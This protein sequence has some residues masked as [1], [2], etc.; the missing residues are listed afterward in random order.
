MGE[1]W[2]ARDTRL[3][4]MV[5]IKRLKVQHSA[6]FEQEA[7]AIAALNHPHICTLHDIGVD[8]L[9]REYVQGQ[10]LNLLSRQS[11]AS[12]LMGMGRL[13]VRF[14]GRQPN[15]DRIGL[16]GAQ[17]ILEGTRGGTYHLWDVWSPQRSGSYENFASSAWSFFGCLIS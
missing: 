13:M 17:W 2:K 15:D 6:R 10:T 5:A 9:V 7:R 8:Y 12:C 16:D 14:W 4:R 1:A 11:L 3:G